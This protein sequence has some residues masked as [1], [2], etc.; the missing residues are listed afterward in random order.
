MWRSLVILTRAVQ[1]WMNI[2]TGR[3]VIICPSHPFS[4]SVLHSREIHFLIPFTNRLRTK[5]HLPETLVE[6]GG[7]KKTSWSISSPFSLHLFHGSDYHWVLLSLWDSSSHWAGSLRF[8]LPWSSENSIPSHCLS[9]HIGGS[10]FV[11]WLILKLP[12]L[13]LV[14]LLSLLYSELTPRQGWLY[15]F[16]C[17]QQN[18]GPYVPHILGHY[19]GILVVSKHIFEKDMGT[20]TLQTTIP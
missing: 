16:F 14:H 10:D 18:I 11:L 15:S 9:N 8:Q 12:Q 5:L 2:C 6:I 20:R 1:R 4:H 7:Q 3:Q 19:P 13:P 17:G